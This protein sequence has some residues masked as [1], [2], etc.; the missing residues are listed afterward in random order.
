MWEKLTLVCVVSILITNNLV[1]SELTCTPP[2]KK[3]HRGCYLFK[4][5]LV[6]WYE[7][8][9]TCQDEGGYLASMSSRAETV[10]VL[11]N[12][13]PLIKTISMKQWWLGLSLNK[14]IAKWKWEDGTD[15]QTTVIAWKPGE[16]NNSLRKEECGEMNIAG[17]LNDQKC[18]KFNPFICEQYPPTAPPPSTTTISSPSETTTLQST[19]ATENLIRTVKTTTFFN[20]NQT[21]TESQTHGEP[22]TSS[23]EN[24]RVSSSVVM[25]TKDDKKVY[26]E[27][28][29]NDSKTNSQMT[30]EPSSIVKITPRPSPIYPKTLMANVSSQ[31]NTS[32]ASTRFHKTHSQSTTTAIG[33][34]DKNG[35]TPLE[36]YEISWPRASNGE[37]VSRPCKTGHG[38]ASWKC[39]D[40][41][42]EWVGRPNIEDCVSKDLRRILNQKLV[43]TEDVSQLTADLVDTLDASKRTVADI[44]TT[45]RVLK[46]I[47]DLNPKDEND[48]RNFA[49]DT[50][51][52]GSL[53]IKQTRDALDLSPDD[54]KRV[55]SVILSAVEDA[56]SKLLDSMDK[57]M[58]FETKSHSILAMFHVLDSNSANDLRFNTGDRETDFLVP[59][60]TIRHYN[61]DGLTKVV[62]L[63]HFNG[64]HLLP[65]P[66]INYTILKDI[67]SASIF[68][69]DVNNLQDPVT[70]TMKLEKNR[71]SGSPIATPLCSFWNFTKGEVGDWSQEGCSLR[72]MNSTHVTCQCN[73]L[74]NFAILMDVSGVELGYEHVMSLTFISYIGCI[75]SII[76]LATSWLTFQCLGSLQG[77]RNSIH[78]NLVFCLFVAEVIFL[79]G[80][81]RTEQKVTCAATALLLHFFFL[82]AFTWMLMEGIHIV[83]MLVQVFDAAKSRLKYYYLVG[84]GAPIIVVG[85]TATADF[86]AYGTDNYC[87]LTTQNW[88][89]WSFA[90]PVALVLVVNAL[91]LFYSMTMVCRHSAYVFTQDRS[92][93]GTFRAW[94]QGAFAIEVLLGLTWVFGYFFINKESVAMAYIFTILN[95]LQGLFI[96]IFHCAMNRKVRGEYKRLVRLSKRVPP[97]TKPQSNSVR[98]Q[99][100]SYELYVP[101]S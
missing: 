74:T 51:S 8:R 54:K 97:T 81:G 58:A 26:T 7:A 25:T 17:K 82:S 84:Y 88:F 70:Y 44:V 6:T 52:I 20:L 49:Q 12:I 66:D 10:R 42:A 99:S 62:F 40:V 9:Q 89:I 33:N 15:L 46:S 101:S 77:E 61:R 36:A 96:F 50:V 34:Q 98:K 45:S 21:F 86:T 87:W 30:S 27:N 23:D 29:L 64:A 13:H 1:Q 55:A 43:T 11:L 76:F 65:V 31:H 39:D 80:I 38:F 63:K 75:V 69:F 53:M 79:I 18:D 22:V 72:D 92:Q 2:W 3:V 67:L 57:P 48:F 83:V 14:T 19:A 59:S 91:V 47:S 78:K 71:F 32:M 94:I 93:S 73:H 100:G 60:H 41:K 24:I 35:C 56:A 85:I 68:G 5:D 95:S 16:P 28:H 90:G 37:V 4:K